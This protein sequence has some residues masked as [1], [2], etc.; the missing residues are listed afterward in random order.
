MNYKQ[1]GGGRAKQGVEDAGSCSPVAPK[2]RVAERRGVGMMT[3]NNM[4]FCPGS[5]SLP[6]T[7]TPSCPQPSAGVVPGRESQSI[8]CL[9]A[10]IST[11]QEQW[12]GEKERGLQ[13][14]RKR[15]GHL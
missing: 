10:A 6:G 14:W 9:P 8:R 1:D 12:K 11:L 3:T 7:H 13:A 15:G 4:A 5:T 2:I